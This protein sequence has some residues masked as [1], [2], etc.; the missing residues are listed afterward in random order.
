MR[1]W[2]WACAWR[3]SSSV[4]VRAWTHLPRPALHHILPFPP[5][6]SAPASPADDESRYATSLRPWIRAFPRDQLHFFQ[7][8]S[9]RGGLRPKREGA[10][11]RGRHIQCGEGAAGAR[12]LPTPFPLHTK[13][14]THLKCPTSQLT[15]AKPTP[16]YE[17]LTSTE[18][19][20]GALSD[21]KRFLGVARK[22]PSEELGLY[23][24]RHQDHA[25]S[26]YLYWG[27][28]GAY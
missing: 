14:T 10:P 25:V 21:I 27:R 9:W 2:A 8:G 1:A 12:R 16:Q 19:M 13:C 3:L 28:A 23:N 15:R 5:I 7:V 20:A 6:P 24:Y 11:C 18:H 17:N 26:L 4:C 22:L